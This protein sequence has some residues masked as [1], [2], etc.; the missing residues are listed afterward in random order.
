MARP[1]KLETLTRT[2]S[3]RIRPVQ[4]VWL[5]YEADQRFEGE[6][7]RALRWALDQAQVFAEI[8][9]EPDPAQALDEMLNPEKYEPPHPEEE[10]AEAERELE[11]WKREQAVK[12]A[13]KKRQ[14]K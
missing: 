11:E 4:D 1:R 14:A 10:I 5:R 12:R 9:R 3:G 8:M 7:S 2:I 6:V 13:Q